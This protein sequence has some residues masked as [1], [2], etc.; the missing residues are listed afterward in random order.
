VKEAT[1]IKKPSFVYSDV[2]MFSD[3]TLPITSMVFTDTLVNIVDMP[4]TN[5]RKPVLFKMATYLNDMRTHYFGIPLIAVLKG[6]MVAERVIDY[7]LFIHNKPKTGVMMTDINTLTGVMFAADMNSSSR[8][9]ADLHL[10]RKV[11]ND[12]A[13]DLREIT[14]DD[15]S[16]VMSIAFKLTKHAYEME[17]MRPV[18]TSPVFSI[19]IKKV[20]SPPIRVDRFQRRLPVNQAN[21]RVLWEREA[22]KRREQRRV[23]INNY[24]RHMLEQQDVN[25]RREQRLNTIENDKSQ[26]VLDQQQ[27]VNKLNNQP[28]V[29]LNTIEKSYLNAFDVLISDNVTTETDI[30]WESNLKKLHV[31]IK[32]CNTL[33]TKDDKHD[34]ARGLGIWV[35]YNS[36]IYKFKTMSSTRVVKWVVFKQ[37]LIDECGNIGMKKNQRRLKKMLSEEPIMVV[38]KLEA[39]RNQFREC[40]NKIRVA[41]N[42]WE[43]K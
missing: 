17:K 25:K 31:Y 30:Q 21:S 35:E 6:R 34:Y 5:P 42:T 28:M 3:T 19:G 20:I 32:G 10:L 27:D 23:K 24:N 4:E 13:H 36:S 26:M 18:T 14:L 29:E 12:A 7:H 9:I 38:E 2:D 16:R 43:L 37:S 8:I 22:Y 11:G 15:V 41:K 33:P 1:V 39:R 40:R